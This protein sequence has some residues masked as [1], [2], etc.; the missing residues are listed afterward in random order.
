VH[1]QGEEAGT[2]QP[3]AYAGRVRFSHGQLVEEK[4]TFSVPLAILSTPKPTTARFYLLDADRQT[5]EGHDEQTSGYDGM[6]I[7][8]RPNR[9][10]GRK[11]YRHH[12]QENPLGYRRIDDVCDDQNRTVKNALNPGANF[13]FTVEFENLSQVELGALLWSLTLEEGWHHRLG[14]AKPLGFGSVKVTIESVVRRTVQRYLTLEGE[15]NPEP[16]VITDYVKIFKEA[17]AARFGVAFDQLEPVQDLCTLL[18]APTNGLPVHYPRPTREPQRE[19]KNYEWFMRN[20]REP[21]RDR[22]G[23]PHLALSLAAE[24][25]QGL[26]LLDKWGSEIAGRLQ[27]SQRPRRGDHHDRQDRHRRHR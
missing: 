8:G 27:Q 25:I 15:A 3:T 6:A 14:S 9:L 1:S 26:P 2:G 22:P 7:Q 17:L 10:R 19:G 5:I 12:G 20:K 13:E 24:D 11:F 23:G 18:T 21:S 4:G 16:F